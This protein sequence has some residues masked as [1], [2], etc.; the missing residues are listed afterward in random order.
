MLRISRWVANHRKSPL[1]RYVAGKCWRFIESFENSSNYDMETNGER[2]VL[3]AL[4][5]DGFSQIFDVGANVGDW[6]LIA[7]EIFP[8]ASVHCFEV[9]PSTADELRANVAAIPQIQVSAF[10]LS[11]I[12]GD[13]ALKTFENLSVLTSLIDVDHGIASSS[14]PGRVMTGDRYCRERQIEHIDLLKIDTEGAEHM[15]FKGFEGMLREGRIDVIQF[16]YGYG[17]L[18]T[19]FMLKDY[20]SLLAGYGYRVGKIYPNYVEFREYEVR[21][22]D[23][24]GPNMIAVLGNCTDSIER[25]S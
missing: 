9:L 7:H 25:L 18:T 11:D 20:Y 8:E 24:R 1:V 6:A 17:S 5:G 15:V 13:V 12:E 23:F 16:E 22:E 4:S 19:K 14:A 10:G 21:H 3:D 2:Q